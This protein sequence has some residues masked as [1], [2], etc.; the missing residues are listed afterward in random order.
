MYS[1]LKRLYDQGRL[2][3]AGVLFYFEKGLITEE[4]KNSILGIEAKATTTTTKK[5]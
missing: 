3:E 1:R 4:E 5:K 2:D